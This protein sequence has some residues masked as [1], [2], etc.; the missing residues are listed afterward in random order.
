MG[1]E[2]PATEGEAKG[3]HGQVGF[4]IRRFNSGAAPHDHSWLSHRT[5]VKSGRG[6]ACRPAFSAATANFGF[7]AK[8]KDIGQKRRQNI[9]PRSC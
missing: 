2:L 9:W 3:G 8:I 4:L 1:A 6:M 5:G 7:R